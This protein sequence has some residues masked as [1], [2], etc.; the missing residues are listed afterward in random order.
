[1][2]PRAETRRFSDV[3]LHSQAISNWTQ[4]YDQISPGA[5]S[6]TL[7]QVSGQRFHVFHEQINQR[8]MQ[9]GRAPRNQLCF[10]LPVVRAVAPI[11]Q[12]RAVSY[13]C[14]LTLRGGDEFIAHLPCDTDVM[15]F[16]I[17][18]T[19]T[20][21]SEYLTLAGLP[22]RILTHPV[23]PVPALRYQAAVNALQSLL[24]EALDG[25]SLAGRDTF[26]EKVLAHS[27]VGILLQLVQYEESD[28]HSLPHTST[29]SYI[30]RKSQ[31]IALGNEDDVLS[32]LDLCQQLKISRRTL[33]Y[34]FQNIAGTTPSA[35]LRS[36]RL[37]AVRRFLMSTPSTIRIGDAAAQFGFCHF[38]RFSSYYQQHFHEL[39]S[40]TPRA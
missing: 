16:T 32:V 20:T 19:F 37:N 15:A 40:Q 8:V 33:Q 25:E 5:A 24:H 21:E 35:Y 30:V 27:L 34:S 28:G 1:M 13:P 2:K 6:T 3:F 7:R 10:A 38:G 12:G 4:R 14:L 26:C 9:Q 29:Q 18:R 39:P 36:I 11:V 22:E 23:L 31:E 17:D